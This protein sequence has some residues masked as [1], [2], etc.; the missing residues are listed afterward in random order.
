M[1]DIKEPRITDEALKK[2]I[3]DLAAILETEAPANTNSVEKSLVGTNGG[4]TPEVKAPELD[5]SLA[6][7]PATPDS[8]IP[9]EGDVQKSAES[10]EYEVAGKELQAE[11]GVGQSGAM[12]KSTSGVEEFEDEEAE[13]FAKSLAGAFMNQEALADLAR[14]DEFAKSLVLASIESLSLATEEIKKSFVDIVDERIEKQTAHTDARLAVLAKGLVAMS[15]AIADIHAQVL[16]V[17]NAP[18]HRGKTA[19]VAGVLQKSFGAETQPNTLEKSQILGALSA[20][21]E[22][23]EVQAFEVVKYETSGQ[24]DPALAV[25]V[26]NKLGHK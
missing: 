12:A 16:A 17:S 6:T 4:L 21:A 26:Q 3:D 13:E 11:M 18:A 22:A 19:T 1:S 9:G 2:S 25:K 8:L 7:Q 5:P 15:K 14:K 23:G 24:L 10:D 20:M